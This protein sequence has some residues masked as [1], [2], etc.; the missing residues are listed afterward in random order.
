MR[1]PLFVFP[2]RFPKTSDETR[3]EVFIYLRLVPDRQRRHGAGISPTLNRE[4]RA[5]AW[6]KMMNFEFK[7]PQCGQMVEADEAYRGQVAEC[8]HCGK[9]IVI[10]RHNPQTRTLRNSGTGKTSHS[11]KHDE[12]QTA[13]AFCRKCG[14]QLNAGENFC[15]KCGAPRNTTGSD[16]AT[17]GSKENSTKKS[18]FISFLK[19]KSTISGFCTAIFIGAIIFFC[20]PDSR[21]LLEKQ[22]SMMVTQILTEHDEFSSFFVIEKAADCLL[23]NTGKNT[24]SGSIDVYCRWKDDEQKQRMKQLFLSMATAANG[25][26]GIPVGILKGF[27]SQL[28]ERPKFKFNIEMVA[29]G[30][31]YHVVCQGDAKQE[32]SAYEMILTMLELRNDE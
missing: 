13:S 30:S 27:E 8:P 11:I 32:N 20:I 16:I 25:G 19:K 29:D 10:P 7:C 26:R 2:Q 1:L 6:S 18:S 22:A 3:R 23:I 4:T 17:S 12:K 5:R 9:G 15:A 21:E 24:Y 14:K 28:G 31:R